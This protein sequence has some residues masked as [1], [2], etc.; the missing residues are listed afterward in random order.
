MYLFPYYAIII[1][2][3]LYESEQ[4]QAQKMRG[5]NMAKYK[6]SNKLMFALVMQD[7]E[8]CAEFIQRLFPGKKVQSITFPNDIKITPEKTIVTGVLSKSVRLDVLFE[9][10]KEVYDIEMQVEKEP[11]LPKR[12]RYY[13]TSMDT[14]FLKKGRPYKDL[15]P[16]YVIFICMK[17]PF[18]MGEA[19]YQFQMI[20]KNLQ[21][22]LNDETY[23]IILAIDCPK[24]KIPKELE[25]FFTY[26]E[27]EEVDEN[28]D[29]VKRIHEKVEEVNRDTEV[30]EIMT[31]EEEM[32][33]RW[34][35]GYD[36]G[37]AAGLEKGR[38]EGE[39]IGA[40]QEKRE[41]AKSMIEEGI[42]KEVI[43][44][45]TG[46]SAEEVEAL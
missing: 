14:H 20:D 30:T 46:L 26:V 6:F 28:D 41:I 22:Q 29:F 37:E 15:K 1:L 11:E 12:S 34:H 44:K 45:I 35:Y 40:A 38:S 31:I 21:L 18:E 39:A 42:A 17:D 36:E 5:K 13:H 4:A 43:E 27:R 16:S 8:I 23:T 33:I 24:G 2:Q 19:I 25:T 9:G 7:E 10:E 32:N 3:N